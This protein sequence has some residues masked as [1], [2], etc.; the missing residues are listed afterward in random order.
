M[1]LCI[2]HSL[3][4]FTSWNCC[5]YSGCNGSGL[6][7]LLHWFNVQVSWIFFLTWKKVFKCCIQMCVMLHIS[8]DSCGKSPGLG[9]RIRDDPLSPSNSQLD[10]VPSLPSFHSSFYRRFKQY[11]PLT[12]DGGV[13]GGGSFAVTSVPLLLWNLLSRHSSGESRPLLQG[14]IVWWSSAA[15]DIYKH[16]SFNHT[17]RYLRLYCSSQGFIETTNSSVK[18]HTIIFVGSHMCNNVLDR[19]VF[20]FLKLKEYKIQHLICRKLVI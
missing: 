7:R 10:F 8:D 1:L 18:Q 9:V 13:S 16:I 5:H 4:R 6:C 2:V 19:M 3:R 15:Q 12:E 11:Q 17:K 20:I 14:R